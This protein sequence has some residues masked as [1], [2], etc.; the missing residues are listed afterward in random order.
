MKHY[1]EY[2]QIIKCIQY[3][4]LLGRNIMFHIT[5]F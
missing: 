3:K 2:K 5:K 4:I 1:L